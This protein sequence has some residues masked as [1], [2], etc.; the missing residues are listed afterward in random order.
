MTRKQAF[1]RDAK[2]RILRDASRKWSI[3]RH[4]N[5]RFR[6]TQMVI[7]PTRKWAFSRHANG[8]FHVTQ[9][10]RFCVTRTDRFCATM[11]GFLHKGQFGGERKSRSRRCNRIPI[12]VAHGQSL[13][14]ADHAFWLSHSV[15]RRFGACATQAR[16]GLFAKNKITPQR[17]FVL[18]LV[19]RH[20]SVPVTQTRAASLRENGLTN[21]HPLP[22]GAMPQSQ[23]LR[24]PGGLPQSLRL[25]HPVRAGPDARGTSTR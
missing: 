25:R 24:E 13:T 1:L 20:I 7:F 2:T 6:V 19:T 8:R 17:N 16:A 10:R 4:A 15:T 9:A 5:G 14:T 12:A 11:N 23:I 3:S 21:W 22:A 18:L